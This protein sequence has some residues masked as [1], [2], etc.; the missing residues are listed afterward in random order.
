[1]T[2]EEAK[3]TIEYL[4]EMQEEYIEGEGYERYPL[5]EW[6]ALEKAIE[7]IEQTTWIPVSERLPKEVKTKGYGLCNVLVTHEWAGITR[8]SLAVF[9]RGKFYTNNYFKH[10]DISVKA[11]MPLPEPYEAESEE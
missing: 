11:W 10:N 1:M 2:P 6:Y 4:K 7:A 8:T 9:D 5:P 3:L